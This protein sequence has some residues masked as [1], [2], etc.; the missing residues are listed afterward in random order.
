MAAKRQRSDDDIIRVRVLRGP[1]EVTVL[2][3][4]AAECV[5]KFKRADKPTFFD[6]FVSFIAH[7]ITS[8]P[9][10]DAWIDMNAELQDGSVFYL[11]AWSEENKAQRAE[12]T[13]A[14]HAEFLRRVNEKIAEVSHELEI[15][16]KR[17][18][19]LLKK[20]RRLEAKLPSKE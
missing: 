7:F 11:Y 8:D 10:G 6:L 1:A 14:Y 19:A 15:P 20:Q 3:A 13:H 18:D 17:L 16:K 4:N 9:D 5:M 2:V 12:L